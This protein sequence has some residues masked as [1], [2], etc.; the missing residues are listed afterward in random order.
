MKSQNL[1]RAARESTERFI[2]F[3]VAA[4]CDM[5][6]KI[7]TL[8]DVTIPPLSLSLHFCV[9]CVTMP[10]HRR[11]RFRRRSHVSALRCDN[12]CSR[13]FEL[14]TIWRC[15]P[16]L[17]P[18]AILQRGALPALPY[19]AC[20][21]CKCGKPHF[22]SSNVNKN[23]FFNDYYSTNPDETSFKRKWEHAIARSADNP[24]DRGI[25]RVAFSWK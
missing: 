24:L 14:R 15:I 12:L 3:F 19:P 18:A 25:E 13:H 17:C 22:A 16:S 21:T 4:D 2:F 9:S 10:P 8:C 23:I 11:A 5:S 7:V 6:F 1:W 20:F